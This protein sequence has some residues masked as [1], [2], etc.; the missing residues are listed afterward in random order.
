M[1][2]IDRRFAHELQKQE[3]VTECENDFSRRMKELTSSILKNNDQRVVTLSGP[4]CSGKTVTAER[5]SRAVTTSGCR[6]IQISIDDYYRDRSDLIEEAE[7]EGRAPDYDSAGSIDLCELERT[8]D[9]IYRRGKVDIPRYDFKK[10][11]R[12]EMI[13]LDSSEYDLVLFEGIQ[14][15]YPEV[16]S[17]F[18]HYPYISISTDVRSGICVDGQSFA[19]REIRLMR[20]LV[21]DVR[22]RNT[23]PAQ[24]FR[25]W[26]TTVIPN[27]EKNILPYSDAADI[28]ID[29][30]MP[31]EINVI[32]T[33][34]L[35]TLEGMPQDDVYYRTAEDLIRRVTPIEPI[36][37]RYIPCDSLYREFIGDGN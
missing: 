10:G 27:E 13:T 20:R 28:K 36:D 3:F 9:G 37:R 29:S 30:L 2:N 23:P 5:I 11:S 16:T 1:L 18:G 33:P 32:R 4:T 14:A 15:V 17:M 8:V 25:L 7:R 35:E 31:Y 19:A 6:M 22:A 12:V 21:R 26:E 34:L 24:T